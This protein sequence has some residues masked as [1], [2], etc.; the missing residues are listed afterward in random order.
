MRMEKNLHEICRVNKTYGIFS[1]WNQ[2]WKYL[3]LAGN[4]KM[5]DI[6][7]GEILTIKKLLEP[8][9]KEKLDAY[10]S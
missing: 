4:G 5:V 3:V 6:P 7:S 2:G 10:L 9:E 1:D 8:A